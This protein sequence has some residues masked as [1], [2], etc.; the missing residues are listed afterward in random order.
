MNN[1]QPIDQIQKRKGIQNAELNRLKNNTLIPSPWANSSNGSPRGSVISNNSNGSF[2][3][4]SNG[5]PR[6]SVI[7]QNGSPK[8]SI[9]VQLRKQIT[10][11]KNVQKAMKL[12]KQILNKEK[13]IK[14]TMPSMINRWK[15]KVSNKLHLDNKNTYTTSSYNN[16]LSKLKNE[17]CTTLVGLNDTKTC[18]RDNVY[19][20]LY[21]KIMVGLT[22]KAP[23]NEN[24]IKKIKS[25]MELYRYIKD[26]YYTNDNT[27]YYIL[28]DKLQQRIEKNAHIPPKNKVQTA[29]KHYYKSHCLQNRTHSTIKRKSKH[30]I[31]RKSKRNHK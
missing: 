25:N 12:K 22:S 28:E 31:K 11:K 21:H 8:Q 24:D 16:E 14:K 10:R 6:G 18:R 9:T 17:Y 4:N 19:N 5:S 30:N 23:L 7:S 15:Q 20:M 1:Y 26:T 2:I 13:Q 27:E 3:S 29:G